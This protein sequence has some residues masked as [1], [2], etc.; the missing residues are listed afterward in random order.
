MSTTKGVQLAGQEFLAGQG[1]D[2]DVQ[3]S[4]DGVGLSQE[5]SV[6]HKL[7]LGDVSELAEFL[8]VLGVSRDETSQINGTFKMLSRI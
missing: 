1:L 2:D 6:A 7:G 8:L 5:V 3:T 4:Q